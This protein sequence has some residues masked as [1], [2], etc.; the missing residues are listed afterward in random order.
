MP[1]PRAPK[2]EYTYTAAQVMSHVA[3]RHSPA[4]LSSAFC[5]HIAFVSDWG[6]YGLYRTHNNLSGLPWNPYYERFG[7]TMGLPD[8]YQRICKFPD[9]SEFVEAYLYHHAHLL[10]LNARGFLEHMQRLDTMPTGARRWEAIA[11]L[12]EKQLAS[13]SGGI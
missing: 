2:P 3:L 10:K 5:A 13:G 9:L 8:N 6:R 4:D 1:E 11:Q 7:A 12:W